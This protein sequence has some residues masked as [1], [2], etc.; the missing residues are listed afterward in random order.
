[1]WPI[2]YGPR[3]CCLYIIVCLK[4]GRIL[5]EILQ[6][7]GFPDGGSSPGPVNSEGHKYSA[8]TAET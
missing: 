4:C 7:F 3:E 2:R 6:C 5:T 8:A 1:M